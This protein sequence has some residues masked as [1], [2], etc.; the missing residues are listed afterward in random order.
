[1][2]KISELYIYPIKS[3]AGIAADSASLT[4]RGFKYDR[5][6]LLVDENNIFLTQREFHQ[7]ALLQ[8]ELMNDGLKVYHKQNIQSQLNVPQYRSGMTSVRHNS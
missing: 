1:M 2:L 6:W 8:V 7:M 5:R 4:D 3:L